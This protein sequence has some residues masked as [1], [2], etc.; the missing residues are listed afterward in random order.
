MWPVHVSK[1]LHFL[2]QQALD[3]LCALGR[4]LVMLVAQHQ[5]GAGL[6]GAIRQNGVQC[7]II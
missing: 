5:H 2:L 6:C 1:N 3:N 7:A 4:R